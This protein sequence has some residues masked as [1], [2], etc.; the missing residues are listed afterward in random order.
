[1][2]GNYTIYPYAVKQLPVHVYC[3]GMNT[4][5]PKEYI[6]VVQGKDRNF[7]LINGDYAH[8][9][10]CNLNPG[11]LTPTHLGPEVGRTQFSK[12]CLTINV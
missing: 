3:A 4:T 1:M 2:D 5:E 12:V 7:A 10:T 8:V 11:V 6:N 9:G